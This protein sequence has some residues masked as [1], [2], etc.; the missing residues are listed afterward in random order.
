MLKKLLEKQKETLDHFFSY[1]D[2]SQCE[3]AF[4]ALKRCQGVIFF[5]GVGKSGYVAQKI[6]ATM[7]STGTKAL[8]LPPI[9]ALHGD[10]GMLSSQDM[11]VVFSKSGETEELLQLLPSVRSKQ[12]HIIAITSN[13][14]S[15]LVQAADL[16]L[17]LPCLTELCPFDLAPT[18]S[19]EI[20]LLIG[21]VLSIAL[22]QAKGFS[23]DSYAENHPGGRIGKRAV[24]KV[25][26][27]MLDTIHAPFCHPHKRLEE[28]LVDFS[29]KRCGCLVVIDENKKLKGIFTDGDLRRALQRK[30]E[31]VLKESLA[32]LMTPSPKSISMEALAW[33]AMKLMEADQKHPVMVLPVIDREKVVGVIKMH[34]IIQAGI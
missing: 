25:K 2:L 19:T 9:D 1:L 12:V 30:G 26:D 33:D 10:L 27:L 24:L 8:Y 15:R 20:Q 11:L 13:H 3:K 16:S 7:M 4:E 21:D 18:T 23:L 34:D 29:D 5:T 22:M 32:N 17:E 6:A 31:N 28:V 14:H